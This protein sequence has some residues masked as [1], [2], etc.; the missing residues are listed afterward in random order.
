[1]YE[2]NITRSLLDALA[3]RPVVVLHGARQTG[4]SWL[5]QKV[6]RGPHL[7]DYLT[8]DDPAVLTAATS[9]PVGFI[10]NLRGNVIIDEVQRA[11]QL[12]I[13]VKSSVDRSRQAGRFLLTG[14]ANILLIP[15][16]SESLAG[17]MEILT[18]WP[19]SQGEIEG[20]QEEFID[21]V[22]SDN[23]L[24][25]MRVS[26]D[27]D[28]IIGRILAGGYPEVLARPG[29]RA[30]WFASYITAILQRD[31]RELAQRIERLAE[32]PRLITALAGRTAM[33]LNTTEL[34]RASGIP[35]RTVHRYL[36]LLEATFLISRVP[37]WTA[38]LRKRLLKTPK[39]IMVDTGLAAYLQSVDAR[40]LKVEPTL[41]GP[42]LETLVITE[43]LKQQ[44]WSTTQPEVAHF[45]TAHGEEVDV[46][47]DARGRLVG[48]EVK[49]A[50]SV[51]SD[52]FRGLRAMATATG[53]RFHRG[54]LFYLGDTA[55]A[56]GPQLYALPLP[57]LWRM[58][59]QRIAPAEQAAVTKRRSH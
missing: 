2:R 7:A 58:R 51:S 46:V 45:R 35:E 17:R 4:K 16:L 54:I 13:A 23:A 52:D 39:V 1:M 32:L 24:A 38:N 18:L 5:A 50:A 3:D 53:R 28:D 14:S 55:V 20:I 42:L 41:L 10:Q 12:F 25:L 44:T 57:T 26:V 49:A 8:L 47:L 30:R 19:L 34:S 56:V 43:L 40:R 27:R 21:V 37:A 11:P 9:D 6:A 29:R 22:F 31:V 59:P 33:L 36:N 15:R 48:I